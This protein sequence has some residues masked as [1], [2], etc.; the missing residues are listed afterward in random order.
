MNRE[1]SESK[2]LPQRGMIQLA[3]DIWLDVEAAILICSNWQTNLRPLEMKILLVLE[4]WRHKTRGYLSADYLASQASAERHSV[5][6]AI[7]TLR[8]K[9][10]PNIIENR[11]GYGY[12]WTIDDD[13]AEAP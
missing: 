9:L 8:M 12:R 10:G 11:T 2:D 1:H 4:H 3:S 13:K 6:T 5:Y 7:Y